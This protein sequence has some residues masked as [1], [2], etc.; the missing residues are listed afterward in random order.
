[1]RKIKTVFLSSILVWSFLVSAQDEGET[2]TIDGANGFSSEETA[3][4]T[5]NSGVKLSEAYPEEINSKN[6]PDMIDSFDYPEIEIKELVNIM[7][8][9]TGKRF[10]T[11]DKLSG[12]ASIQSKD[13][14]TVAEAWQAFLSVLQMNDLTIV[15]AGKFLKIVKS[16]EAAKMSIETYTG[17][18]FPNSDQMIT[19]IIKLKYIPVDELEKALKDLRSKDGE[20]KSYE[21]TNSIIIT[22]YGSSVEK[23]L[24]IIEELD[25]PGFEE[26]MKVIPV[27]YAVA[28]RYC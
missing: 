1:M 13:P 17:E 8:E 27:K 19:K 20:M 7:G 28:K 11:P 15:P 21:P 6:Y 3:I 10:I 25:V 18:Y 14:I 16:R 23:L 4:P 2:F 26:N 24:R 12:K 22:D 9:L 5:S